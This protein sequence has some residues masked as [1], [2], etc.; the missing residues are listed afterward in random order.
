MSTLIENKTN[1]N[2]KLTFKQI[3]TEFLVDFN[4]YTI[5]DPNGIGQI[6]QGFS[7]RSPFPISSALAIEFSLNLQLLFQCINL[8]NK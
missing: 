3:L 4:P 5:I 8:V 6:W 7:P 2:K 1:V